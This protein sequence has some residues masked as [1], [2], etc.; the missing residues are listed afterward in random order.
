MALPS[1]QGLMGRYSVRGFG[2]LARGGPRGFKVIGVLVLCMSHCLGLFVGYLTVVVMISFWSTLQRK[3]V[4]PTTEH[5]SESSIVGG[6]DV[7]VEFDNIDLAEPTP[8]YTDKINVEQFEDKLRG[9]PAFP[10]SKFPPFEFDRRHRL[11]YS[12]R[13]SRPHNRPPP[14]VDCRNHVP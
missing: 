5:G 3:D 6:G 13:S 4:A 12:R 14:H 9:Q 1:E 10:L 7:D 2:Y 11:A 8:V